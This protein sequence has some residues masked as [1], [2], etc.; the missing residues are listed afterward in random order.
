[1]EPEPRVANAVPS[2]R[3]CPVRVEPVPNIIDSVP[4]GV[5]YAVSVMEPGAAYL[6]PA[7]DKLDCIDGQSRLA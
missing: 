7:G 1:M 5:P 6:T 2:G 4:S 3:H